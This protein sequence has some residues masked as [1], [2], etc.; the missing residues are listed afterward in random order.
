MVVEDASGTSKK[1][2][3]T[4]KVGSRLFRRLKGR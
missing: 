1:M 4:D 2:V 3:H